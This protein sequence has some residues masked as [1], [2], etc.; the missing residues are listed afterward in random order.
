MLYLDYERLKGKYINAQ[1]TYNEI[2][3]EKER[4]FAKT[5]PKAIKFDRESVGGGKPYTID[6]Y[7]VEIEQKGINERLDQAWMILNERKSVLWVKEQELRASKSLHDQIYKYRYLD[8]MRPYRI[9]SRIGYSESQVYRILKII[10]HNLKDA[11]KCEK[12]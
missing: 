7:L 5:Q 1:K 9:A 11:R 2:L 10:E 3:S 8:S 12:T 6:D 4:L